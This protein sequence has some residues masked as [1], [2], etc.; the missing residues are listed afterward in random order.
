MLI[1]ERDNADLM[2]YLSSGEDEAEA[3]TEVEV[4]TKLLRRPT[5]MMS[6]VEGE[7]FERITK[8]D[9]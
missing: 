2:Q 8:L 7:A 6:K 3:K 4:Q 5:I 9:L 1:F